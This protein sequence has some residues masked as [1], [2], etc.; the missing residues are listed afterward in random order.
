MIIVWQLPDS[1]RQSANKTYLDA[2]KFIDTQF[3]EDI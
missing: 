3:Q 2:N 1:R